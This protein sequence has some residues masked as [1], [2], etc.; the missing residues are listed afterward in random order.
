MDGH[1][2]Y[3]KK[4]T[5]ETQGKLVLSLHPPSRKVGEKKY[6]PQKLKKV[7]EKKRIPDGPGKGSN[8]RLFH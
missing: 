5:S 2:E 1:S 4:K 6:K 3:E 7:S 8:Y